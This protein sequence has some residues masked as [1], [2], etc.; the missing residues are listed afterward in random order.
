MKS[1]LFII[2]LGCYCVLAAYSYGKYARSAKPHVK[3][4][5]ITRAVMRCEQTD[6][7]CLTAWA[8]EEHPTKRRGK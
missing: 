6:W 1:L 8:S 5:V 3:P 4:V 2:P 7:L